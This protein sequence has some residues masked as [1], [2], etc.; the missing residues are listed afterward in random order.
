[1][2]ECACVQGHSVKCILTVGS[3]QKS[4]QDVAFMQRN[5]QCEDNG[6]RNVGK[7]IILYL[8][9]KVGR[10]GNGKWRPEPVLPFARLP[11][12]ISLDLLSLF[13]RTVRVGKIA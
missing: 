7:V 9:K 2:W 13:K 4:L 6:R 12:Q 11:R 10:L 8:F 1:M 5:W 3:D